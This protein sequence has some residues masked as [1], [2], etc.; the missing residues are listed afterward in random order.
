MSKFSI[1]LDTETLG[2][3]P[4]SIITE[5][6]CLVFETETFAVVR[7]QEVIFDIAEQLA[8]FRSYTA[9]TLAFHRKRGTLPKSLIGMSGL[10]AALQIRSIFQSYSH[11]HVWIQGPDFDRPLLENFFASQ[12]MPLPWEFWKTRDCRTAYDLAF[13]GKK[14][15]SRPHKALEDCHAT[16]ADLKLSLEKLNLTGHAPY[17]MIP[18][19]LSEVNLLLPRS[20]VLAKTSTPLPH[21]P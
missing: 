17:T 12:N 20:A 3:D 8:N 16:L 13:P 18:P 4:S 5:F 2:T 6:A 11:S 9:D 1:I 19:T 15:P 14:H 10:D 7:E 21:G